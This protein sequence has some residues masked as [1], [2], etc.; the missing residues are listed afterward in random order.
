LAGDVRRVALSSFMNVATRGV[1]EQ[2]VRE[3]VGEV[4]EDAAEQV[5]IASRIVDGI[6]DIGG[7]RIPVG[8][9]ADPRRIP[10]TK[11]FEIPRHLLRLREIVRDLTLGERHLLLIGN[12]GT[13]KNKLTDHLLELLRWEREY[14]QLHRDTTVS[15]LT[16]QASLEQ[17]KVIWEDSPLVQAVRYGRVLVVDEADKAPLEVVCILKGLVEDGEMTLS[18]GRRILRDA[19]SAA[20][21]DKVIAIHPEFKMFLLANRPGF[22][23]QGNDLFRE[24]GDVYAPHI[25]ENP[26]LDSEV[27]LL[28][29]YAPDVDIN[30]LRLLSSAFTELRQQVDEGLLTYPYSTRE[31]VNISRHL[32]QFPGQSIGSALRDILDFDRHD[33]HA[34]GTLREVLLRWGI[35]LD[36]SVGGGEGAGGTVELAPERRLPAPALAERWLLRRVGRAPTIRRVEVEVRNCTYLLDVKRGLKLD[37]IQGGRAARFTEELNR[38]RFPLGS[39]RY[40]TE[41]AASAVVLPQ[42]SKLCVLVER[43]TTGSL[44][45][46][47]HDLAGGSASTVCDRYDASFGL[48]TPM[49]KDTPV[50]L[51]SLGPDKFG[52]AG[53]RRLYMVSI[54]SEPAVT[55]LTLPMTMFLKDDD[56]P[57]RRRKPPAVRWNTEYAA[58]GSAVVWAPG[59]DSI[60]LLDT[61]RNSGRIYTVPKL[62]VQQ[63]WLLRSRELLIAGDGEL[64]HLDASSEGLDALLS[65]VF[66]D[67]IG[68]RPPLKPSYVTGILRASLPA[69]TCGALT[70]A[71]A[72]CGLLAREPRAA[73]TRRQEVEHYNK[74]AFEAKVWQ[75]PAPSAT[76]LHLAVLPGGTF[77]SA[78]AQEV[79]QRRHGLLRFWTWRRVC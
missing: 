57:E 36:A 76:P 56:P 71:D 24:T 9:G 31:L 11:F 41:I 48:R 74:D 49:R 3:E 29:N 65:D 75:R 14:I 58:E 12:Q 6:L 18:D 13:G 53:E 26:D 44:G 21:G 46:I 59:G 63:V 28:R 34:L 33:A 5:G 7:S 19:G 25:I 35:P 42:S 47:V 52:L 32:Q 39:S 4:R 27:R 61:I 45:V 50:S 64:L 54:G 10:Q 66:V 38:W 62:Q 1:F 23:F 43:T 15:A 67:P 70:A 60:V 16:V 30:S 2:L 73:Y 79:H 37:G 77:V 20:D 78:F 22:P 8:V 68:E 72:Y 55:E 51:F 40:D 17:G 69:D